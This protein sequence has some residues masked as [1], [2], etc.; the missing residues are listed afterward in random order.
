MRDKTRNVE[1]LQ[2]FLLSAL[3]PIGCALP[4]PHEPSESEAARHLEEPAA[5]P[6][7]TPLPEPPEPPASEGRYSVSVREVPARE[8]LYSLAEDA[9]LD[10]DIHSEAQGKVTMIALDQPLPALLQR[11][12]HQAGL[13][14]E[15]LPDRWAVFPDGPFLRVYSVDYLNVKRTSSSRV[16]VESQIASTGTSSSGESAG[17][18][19]STT[20]VSGETGVDFWTS[21]QENLHALL[22]EDRG[23]VIVNPATG[24]IAVRTDSEG[25][26]AVRNLL[27][28]AQASAQRQVLI[29]ATIVEVELDD[30]YRAGIDWGRLLEG[31]GLSVEWGALPLS[32]ERTFGG[33]VLDYKRGDGLQVMLRLLQEFGRTRVLSSPKLM[34]LNNQTAL[35]KVVDNLVYFTVEQQTTLSVQGSSESSSRST[36]HTVPIG[37]TM[38]ITPQIDARGSV[39]LGVR[40]TVSR[41]NR[42][43]S[44]PNPALE[45]GNRVPEIQVRELESLLRLEDGHVAVLGGLIRDDLGEDESRLPA[46]ADLPWIGSLFQGRRRSHRR[47]ELVI[48]LRPTV[49]WPVAGRSRTIGEG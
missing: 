44:D 40:P 5:L 9:G 46:I 16:R 6:E 36:V 26:R 18:S 1:S 42:F 4:G 27:D 38:A 19:N 2:I 7:L 39:M 14:L 49:I 10:L 12:A 8:L 41:V 17:G 21:L 33:F 22:E 43:V 20:D 29:Q 37:L 48:L 15:R 25:H 47:T 35:L 11:I 28:A 3:L 34:S 13:R 31:N 45:D 30:R 24:V 23:E 32:P